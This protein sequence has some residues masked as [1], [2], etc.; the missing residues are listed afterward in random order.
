MSKEIAQALLNRLRVAHI[1]ANVREIDQ[2]RARELLPGD[3][4]RH[5]GWI[6]KYSDKHK[7]YNPSQIEDRAR[8][9]AN[10]ANALLKSKFL[11]W[12]HKPEQKTIHLLRRK[13]A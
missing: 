12:L 1:D 6:V 2:K 3:H 4:V 8:S 7:Y 13:T 9:E 5:T 11:E 10:D